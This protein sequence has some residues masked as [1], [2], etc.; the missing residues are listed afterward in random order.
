M[1]QAGLEAYLV[2]YN[3]KEGV[4]PIPEPYRIYGIKRKRID[5]VDD[6]EKNTIISAES[7]TIE[8]NRFRKIRKIFEVSVNWLD[9]TPITARLF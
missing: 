9:N 6:T 7:S 1:E 3:T 4:D 8:L 5:E 2:Y